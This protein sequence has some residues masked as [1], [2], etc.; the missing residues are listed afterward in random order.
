M[1]DFQLEKDQYVADG[2]VV[3][4]EDYVM[5]NCQNYNL[6]IYFSLRKKRDVKGKISFKRLVTRDKT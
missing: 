2:K 3:L 4:K 5:T 1:R 6:K